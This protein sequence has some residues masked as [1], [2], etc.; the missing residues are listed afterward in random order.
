LTN[1]DIDELFEQAE[2]DAAAFV[3][4]RRAY[5]LQLQANTDLWSDSELEDRILYGPMDND[6]YTAVC[7]KLHQALSRPDSRGRWTQTQ[8]ARFIKSFTHETNY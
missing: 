7:I 3:E 4:A 2:Q 1:N 8:M 6:N 5:L